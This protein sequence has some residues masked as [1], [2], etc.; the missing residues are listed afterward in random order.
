MSLCAVIPVANM[1]AANDTLNAAGFGPSNFSVPAYSGS[2]PRVT[3]AA[4][5][6]WDDLLFSNAIKSIP[7][8]VFNEGT[9]NPVAR[10][11]AL[12]EAQGAQWAAAAPNLSGNLLANKLYR[13]TD[14]TL[15]WTIQA[16]NASVFN[17]P[18][19]NYP[20][21]IRL[22]RTPG[23]YESWVQPLGAGYEYK[24]LDPFTGSPEVCSHLGKRWRTKIDNNVW[25]P[26]VGALW[27]EITT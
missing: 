19:S 27:A 26:A 13:Y 17:L 6:A 9:G 3:H 21:L 4:L 1:K 10:I 14:G 8:V 20:A 23:A 5:H 15:W 22:A 11:K 16:Y 7:N 2:T 18:P 12:I 24:L 25:E